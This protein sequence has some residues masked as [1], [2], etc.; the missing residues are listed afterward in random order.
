MYMQHC[1]LLADPDM[2]PYCMT[3]YYYALCMYYMYM[4]VLSDY[5]SICTFMNRMPASQQCL[6]GKIFECYDS[7]K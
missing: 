7:N 3:V 6:L 1:M 4:Q 5:R 2:L